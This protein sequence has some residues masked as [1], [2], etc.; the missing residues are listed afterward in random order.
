L[1]AFEQFVRRERAKAQARMVL[2][3]VQW[4]KETAKA[5]LFRPYAKR[6]AGRTAFNG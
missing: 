5:I 1:Y 6:P 4:L 3:A 2:A